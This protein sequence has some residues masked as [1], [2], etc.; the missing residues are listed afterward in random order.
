MKK[1]DDKYKAL[2]SIFYEDTFKTILPLVDGKSITYY[3]TDLGNR[4]N[5]L[6]FQEKEG[7]K[8]KIYEKSSISKTGEYGFNTNKS[9]SSH[10]DFTKTINLISNKLF[11]YKRWGD[12]Y[13]AQVST[14]FS[15][16]YIDH[17]PRMG[18]TIDGEKPSR[19]ETP[20]NF[21]IRRSLEFGEY[22][23]LWI[24]KIIND[25]RYKQGTMMRGG[26]TKNHITI[27]QNIKIN[28]KDELRSIKGISI[29][30]RDNYDMAMIFWCNEYLFSKYREIVNMTPEQIALVD[31]PQIYGNKELM[32]SIEHIL[33]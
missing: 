5:D 14:I 28:L 4:L 26:H 32:R 17:R 30:N 3:K 25:C 11:K 6:L 16:S 27:N 19:F 12:S 1:I 23:N 22:N 15:L 8:S 29:R 7:H 31:T 18:S 21:E 24:S 10:D 13:F 2:Y 33:V 20:G 9:F